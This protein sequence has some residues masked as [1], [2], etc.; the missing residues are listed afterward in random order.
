M[1]FVRENHPSLFEG[2]KARGMYVVGDQMIAPAAVEHEELSEQFRRWPGWQKAESIGY[3]PKVADLERQTWETLDHVTC[4]SDYVKQGL[5]RAGVSD[6]KVSVL[7]YP[8]DTSHYPFVDRS[9]SRAA[10][11]PVTVGFVGHVNLRKGVPYF[12]EVAKRLKGRGIRF[13][14]VGGVHLEPAVVEANRAFVDFVGP[15]PRAEVA[16]W[17]SR[18]DLLLFPSTCEGS[19]AAVVEA[20]ASGLPI[21][22]SP[23]SGSIVRHGTEGYVLPYDQIDAMAEAV[24][25]L[26]SNPSLRL[27]MG[28]AASA[29]AGAFTI[30][31]YSRELAGVLTRLVS[32][33]GSE[34]ARVI[35]PAQI[36]QPSANL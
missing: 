19:A 15:V 20:M 27:E 9:Q 28:R 17:L 23:N 24:D 18:F 16:N 3:L 29:R 34:D 11:D 21:V 26:A 6:E 32:G 33:A 14:M 35:P 36:A 7:P 5:L 31:W 30:D 12:V 2:A 22:C 1:G 10:G 8:L 25:R 4:A 13:V